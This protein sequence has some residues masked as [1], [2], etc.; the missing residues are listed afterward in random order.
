MPTLTQWILLL[1]V[2]AAVWLAAGAFAGAVVRAQGKRASDLAGKVFALRTGW[3]LSVLFGVPGSIVAGATG[4]WL[5]DPLG[6]GFKPGWVH[7]SIG[8]WALLLGIHLA[9]G[10]PRLKRTVAAAEAS[11]AS[12]APSVELQKLVSSKAPGIVAD[13]SA[14][15]IVVLIALMVLKPF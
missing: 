9:W 11:L 15:G 8:L 2:L 10:L 13:V 12:G 6:Y 1:H 14:L 4:L 5:L 3:R 7:A